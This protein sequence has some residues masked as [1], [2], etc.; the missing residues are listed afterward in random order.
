MPLTLTPIV[1]GLTAPTGIT[2]APNNNQTAFVLDQTGVVWKADLGTQAV[3][4]FLDIKSQIVILNVM[5]D[6]RG[7][8]GLAFHPEFQSAT[9][10]NRGKFYVF[11]STPTRKG[12]LVPDPTQTTARFYNC[13]SEFQ[14]DPL[15]CVVQPNSERPLMCTAQDETDH[16]GGQIAF[17]PDGFLYILVGD[18]GPQE[19][20]KHKGQNPYSVEGKVLRISVGASTGNAPYSIPP[21]NPYISNG[22][23]EVYAIGLRNPWGMSWDAAG[24]FFVADT[25]YKTAEEINIVVKGGNYGWRV[26]EGREFS[27]WATQQEKQG[28]FI[29]PIYVYPN[30]GKGN[31]AIGGYSPRVGQYIFG[32]YS[33]KIFV[34]GEGQDGIWVEQESQGLKGLYV[35][36]FGQSPDRRIYLLTSGHGAPTGNKGAVYLIS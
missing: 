27:P 28:Q 14:A 18:G 36:G 30:E 11:Y 33:G 2:F 22:A 26:K 4:V 8:L 1:S 29:D 25:G 34:I 10:P 7:L 35:R 5:Y 15:T 13:L 16:N 19:D 17:G 3:D 20:P 21:N 12:Y 24:R 6:E 31:A 32:D 23:P 9:S